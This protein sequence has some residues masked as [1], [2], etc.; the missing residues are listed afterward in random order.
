MAKGAYVGASN[1]ARK[2]KKIFVGAGGVARKV[3]K[4]Y[5]GVNGVAK[6]FYSAETSVTYTGEYTKGE[7]VVDGVKHVLYTLLTSGTL[8][9]DG[10]ARVWACGG[11][12]S[13]YAAKNTNNY[14]CETGHGGAGAYAMEA[15]ITSGTYPVVI[16]SG[17]VGKEPVVY[18]ATTGNS[19]GITSIGS[20]AV[21]TIAGG[22]G[23]TGGGGTFL[24]DPSGI[25]EHD[26]VMGYGDGKPKYPF[27]VNSLN[28]HCAGGAGGI[29][30]NADSYTNYYSGNGGTN[31]GNGYKA[32]LSQQSRTS[33]GEGGEKGGGT[34]RAS[35]DDANK[36][37]TFYGS[38]GAGGGLSSK[39]SLFTAKTSGSGYQGVV[40][41]L[42]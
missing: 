19:G 12:Q 13:G 7:L 42:V 3:K 6:L 4:G 25:G 1:V 35:I 28:C 38:G 39:S 29:Y 20:F 37:A 17:G 31:G 16:G 34:M 41:V 10:A 5:V 27:G 26:D 24:V 30:V 33:A 21:E 18:D 23:G 36:N 8:T 40:Y 2:V 9:I 15:A 14:H 22:H 11:G 32:S